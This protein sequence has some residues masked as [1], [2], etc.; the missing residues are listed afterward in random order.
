MNSHF[1]RSKRHQ[2]D[3]SHVRIAPIA[4]S[5]THYH[6]EKI[7]ALL[8]IASWDQPV[9][10]IKANLV[11]PEKGDLAALKAF[12]KQASTLSC[13][14]I[15]MSPGPESCH[16]A[17]AT[18]RPKTDAALQFASEGQNLLSGLIEGNQASIPVW[19][20]CP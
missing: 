1:G 19:P 8:G 18:S 10:K 3:Q 20:L 6:A 4:A 12:E 2:A 15:P 13:N 11:F 16:V 9:E 14:S 5:R 7:S 17:S